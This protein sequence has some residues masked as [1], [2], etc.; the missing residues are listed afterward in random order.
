MPGGR[1]GSWEGINLGL[2]AA[3]HGGEGERVVEKVR[4]GMQKCHEVCIT[5]IPQMRRCR[6]SRDVTGTT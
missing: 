2:Q 6:L 1:P 3:G 4:R 5:T